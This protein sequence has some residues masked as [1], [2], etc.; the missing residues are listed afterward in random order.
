MIVAAVVRSFEGLISGS[1]SATAPILLAALG[2][3]YTYFSGIFNIAMEAMMLAG[4][5]G[6][7]VVGHGTGNW[8]FG[9]LG[10]IGAA[11]VLAM[12]FGVFVLLLHT[13]EFVTGIALN[14]ATVGATTFLLRRIYKKAGAFSGTADHPIPAIPKVRL[15]FLADL[16]VVRSIANGHTLIEWA[17]PL[18][19]IGSVLLLYRT[20]F[21]L[22][23]RAAGWNPASL[24]ASGVSTR[25]LRA[26]S[27]ALCAF[28]C[29]LAGAFLSLG[30]LQ[31]FGENMSNGRGWISLAAIVLVQGSPLGI[32]ALCLLFGVAASVGLKAQGVHIAPQFTE[33]LP[34]LATLAALY[35]YARRRRRAAERAGAVLVAAS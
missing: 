30:Y 26:Q 2:G 21:G 16:P 34:Y 19:V 20:R 35:V 29:G 23:L 33:M 8:F 24:D 6:G 15:P 28:F 9:V 14:L 31:L 18:L 1:I 32:S 5:F 13:D 22:R 25:R 11:G 17:V 12:L 4:A 10:A 3:M 7:V 27:L